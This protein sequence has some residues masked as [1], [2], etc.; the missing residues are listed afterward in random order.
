MIEQEAID[1]INSCLKESK[2]VIITNARKGWVE[3]SSSRFMPKLHI[4][5]MKF[6]KIVSARIYYEQTANLDT[7]KWKEL[8]F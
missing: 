7:Y 1:L 5:V 3:Y 8:A 4:I 6:V 2:V